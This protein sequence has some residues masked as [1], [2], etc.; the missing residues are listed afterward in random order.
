MQRVKKKKRAFVFRAYVA[1]Y[2]VYF[3]GL[4]CGLLKDVKFIGVVCTPIFNFS[5]SPFITGLM[6]FITVSYVTYYVSQ[7]QKAEEKEIQRNREKL[8]EQKKNDQELVGKLIKEPIKPIDKILNDKRY[9][10]SIDMSVHKGDT[11]KVLRYLS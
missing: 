10:N 1:I 6:S 3:I 7:G 4:L 9:D 2:V 5:K 11:N 8:A